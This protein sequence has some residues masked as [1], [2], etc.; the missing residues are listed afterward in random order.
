MQSVLDEIISVDCLGNPPER[1]S[2]I[3]PAGILISDH[4]AARRWLVSVIA[5]RAV[6]LHRE[7]RKRSGKEAKPDG[8][9][10]GNAQG[11]AEWQRKEG[12]R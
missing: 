4:A 11:T 6:E 3:E 9:D 12:R 5:A 10:H 8:D 7:R 1:L 2:T